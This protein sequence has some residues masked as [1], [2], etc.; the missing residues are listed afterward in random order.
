MTDANGNDPRPLS[1]LNHRDDFPLEG[2][3]AR[4]MSAVAVLTMLLVIGAVAMFV[5]MVYVIDYRGWNTPPG[6]AGRKTVI[7]VGSVLLITLLVL[8]RLYYR[9]P[10]W[11]GWAYGIWIGLGTA[12]LV[13]GICFGV[14]R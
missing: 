3:L 1:Y 11:R 8:S 10:A 7:V 4:Q 13:E 9:D 5:F 14:Y 6:T 2:K 12:L